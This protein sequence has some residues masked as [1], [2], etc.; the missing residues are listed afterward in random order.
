MLLILSAIFSASLF[1]LIFYD[2]FK[3]IAATLLSVLIFS[4]ILYFGSF[5]KLIL[6]GETV[7]QSFQWISSLDIH[8]TFYLDGLSLFFALL[9]TGMGLLVF[10]YSFQYMEKYP[11]KRYFFCYLLFFMGAMLG[12]V[13]S[14]NLISLF[15]FWELTSFSSFLLIGFNN[16]NKG[17]R[18]AARQALLVTSGGG[19]ALMSGFILL[20]IINSNGFDLIA[21]LSQPEISSVGDLQLFAIILI[22]IGAFSKSAQFPFHFWLPNAMAAPTPVSAYLHSATMVKAG[23]YL[24]FRL[25]PLFDTIPL[26]TALLGIVGA[27]TM[28]LGAFLALQED[29]LKRILAY[30]TISALG[31]FFM[32][33]GIGGRNALNAVIIYVLAHAI[34]KGG[35]FLIAGIIERQTGSRNIS[36]LSDL[37]RKMPLTA[38]SVIC[39]TA[40]MSGIIPFLGFIGKESLYEALY[41][42][43]SPFS[44]VYLVLLIISSVFFVAISIEIVFKA[45]FRKGEMQNKKIAESAPLMLLGPIILALLGIITAV[46]PQHT[47]EPILKLS[48]SAI[49]QGEAIME[50]KLWHGFNTV[51]LLSIITILGGFAVY[52]V[53]KYIRKFKKPQRLNFDYLYDRFISGTDQI[54][55]FITGQIQNGYLRNYIATLIFFFSALMIYVLF[56]GDFINRIDI[57]NI[58]S[59]IQIYEIVIIALVTMAVIFLFKTKS[60]LIVTATFGIIG[61]SIALAYTLFSAPDVA[62]TQFLAETLTLILLILILHRLPSYTLKNKIAHNKYLPLAVLFGLVMTLTSFTLLNRDRNSG[63]KTFFLEKSLTAGKGKNAVNVILTDFRALDTLGEITVLTITMIGIIA[64]L[65]INNRK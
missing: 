34:Y 45:F 52:Y 4:V 43:Q 32:M 13:L 2:S 12:L 60:R 41:H 17:S 38:F 30:T 7:T 42:S 48:A 10:L 50:L 9:I 3:K 14:A 27:I 53:L 57:Q 28:T 23:V 20:E 54:A 49:Y 21:L 65:K 25:N 26:W 5:S 59:E 39:A 8:L 40:S 11:G 46:L 31:I 64:L 16:Q 37:Y 35:L 63:L 1:S 19:L 56:M 62:I 6:D 55:K 22:A 44:K 51:L 36:Q 33:T 18:R 24:I 58:T 29:D 47:I 15:I 61:Y